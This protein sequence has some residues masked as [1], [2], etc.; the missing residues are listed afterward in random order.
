MVLA[1]LTAVYMIPPI[2]SALP[3]STPPIRYIVFEEMDADDV[4]F[5]VGDEVSVA[6][7]PCP[8]MLDGP[9]DLSS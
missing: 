7:S 5:D 4:L 8:R 9:E 1:H 6:E 2:R 3:I